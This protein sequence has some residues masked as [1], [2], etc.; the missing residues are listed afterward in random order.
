MLDQSKVKLLEVQPQKVSKEKP[1][2]ARRPAW[3]KASEEEKHLYTPLLDEKLQNILKPDELKCSDVKCEH[4][5]PTEARDKHVLDVVAAIEA[6]HQ[7]IPMQGTMGEPRKK[8]KPDWKE[9]VKP[10]RTDTMFCHRV[11][12][13]ADRP[14]TG[15]IFDQMKDSQNQYH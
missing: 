3:F 4:V 7:S 1:V 13:C 2:R 9:K 15:N 10:Q 8:T 14:N 12:K 5:H 6:S 11:W